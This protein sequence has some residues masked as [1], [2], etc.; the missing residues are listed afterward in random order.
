MPTSESSLRQ[1][2]TLWRSSIVAAP[3]GSVEYLNPHGSTY[4]GQPT[5]ARLGYDWVT[6]FHPDDVEGIPKVRCRRGGIASRPL[7]GS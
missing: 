3:D 2:P 1:V 6:F 4:V 7:V 5:G